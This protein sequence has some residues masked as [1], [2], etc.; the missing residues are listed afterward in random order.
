MSADKFLDE[1]EEALDVVERSASDVQSYIDNL[2]MA[3]RNHKIAQEN[4]TKLIEKG[5]M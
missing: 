5:E 4:L 2:R 3:L 1:I